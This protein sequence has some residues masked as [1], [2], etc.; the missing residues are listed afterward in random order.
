VSTRAGSTLVAIALAAALVGGTA[1]AQDATPER[2]LAEIREMALYAR[3]REALAATQTFLQRAD[4]SAVQRNTGLEV[5]A[6]V[7]IALRDQP[8]ATQVLQQLYARDPAHQLSDPDASP[9]VLSAFGRARAHPPSAVAVEIV[10]ETPA[11]P[12]RRPPL[13]EVRLGANGDAVDELRVRYRQGDDDGF[14]TVVMNVRDGVATARLPVLDRDEAYTVHYVIEALAPSGSVLAAQGTDT[15]PL[16]L[17]M[18]EARAAAAES[19]S[20]QPAAA[21]G[22]DLWWLW[23]IIGV[24]IAAG[25]AVGAYFIVQEVTAP[26]NGSLDTIQLPLVRF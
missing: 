20:A 10:H 24:A 25:G 22:D 6:T 1:Q 15:E 26:A 9:P 7:H 14:T 23:T 12:A 13:L 5:L 21:G 17:A 2:A 3:Y 19:S 18:P 16:A 4:L 11:L 8:A